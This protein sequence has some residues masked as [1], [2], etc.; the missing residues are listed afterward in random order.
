MNIEQRAHDLVVRCIANAAQG[1]ED[2]LNE[3]SDALGAINVFESKGIEVGERAV[4]ILRELAQAHH[5]TF[6]R[7]QFA[8]LPLFQETQR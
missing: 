8:G 4:I 3:D 5:E 7:D 6:V 1:V 2:R